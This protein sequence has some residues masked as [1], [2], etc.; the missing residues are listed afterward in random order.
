MRAV[1]VSAA[2][3]GCS[4][5]PSAV[6]GGGADAVA[7]AIDAPIDG[8]PNVDTDGDGIVDAIDN[9]PTVANPDQRDWD[10]DHHGDV[11]DHCPHLASA[12]DPDSDGDGVGDAC[13]PRPTLAGDTAVMWN[14]F[15]TSA[16]IA[17]WYDGGTGGTGTWAVTNGMLV[18]SATNPNQ[19]AS[20]AAPPAYQH[21][22]VA[23]SFVLG[24]MNA[25]ATVGV[26][27]GWDGTHFDCCNLNTANQAPNSE[28]E[29]QRDL[30]Q[31]VDQAW[32]PALAQGQQID[33]VQASS[34][35]AN[36]CA[37]GTSVRTSST[38]AGIV[39]HVI[40]YTGHMAAS[41]RYVFVVTIGS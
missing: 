12:S 17:G 6:T 31:K 19:F 32:S 11:C 27:N 13:D 30:A 5:A 39:G 37:F 28:A 25:S 21:V 38:P 20:F 36:D 35:T 9:C 14:G 40:F 10:G 22:Y 2:L 23:T 33:V 3:A 1:V 4:F 41:F 34:A 16:D 24:A 8:S 29:A 18:Q 15:Y 26:C 7:D